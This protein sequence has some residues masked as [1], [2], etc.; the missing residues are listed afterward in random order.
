MEY[1]EAVELVVAGAMR[2]LQES[3]HQV[4]KLT[5]ETHENARGEEAAVVA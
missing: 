4:Q 1:D 2:D 5:K 3:S